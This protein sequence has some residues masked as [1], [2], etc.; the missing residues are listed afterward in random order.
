MLR[1]VLHYCFPNGIRAD[2]CLYN[3]TTTRVGGLTALV[4]I[5]YGNG[6]WCLVEPDA[7]LAGRLY[8]RVSDVQGQPRLTELY[9]DGRGE[10]ISPRALRSLPLAAIEEWAGEG[11]ATRRDVAGPDLSR[12]A[13]HYGTQWGTGAYSGEHCANCQ[14]PLRGI[15]QVTDPLPDRALVDW[16]ALSWFAQHSLLDGYNIPQSPMGREHKRTTPAELKLD[17]PEDGRLSD[18]FLRTVAKA[19]VAAV[20]RRLPPAKTLA[21]LAAVSPRTVHRWCYIARKRGLMDPA[22]SRGRIA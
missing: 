1:V 21:Q 6:G 4:Q 8:V 20:G 15:K 22:S 17:P 7:D 12:L 18:E 3:L 13:S 14:A 16:V 5:S 10:R 2:W 9:I 19:Y 11:S